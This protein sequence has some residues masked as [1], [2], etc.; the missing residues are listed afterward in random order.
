MPIEPRRDTV[1]DVILNAIDS[2]R[3]DVRD[4]REDGIQRGEMLRKEIS[5]LRHES[6]TELAALKPLVGAHSRQLKAYSDQLRAHSAQLDIQAKG[7]AQLENRPEKIVGRNIVWIA[8][9][10]G[11]AAALFGDLISMWLRSLAQ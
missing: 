6:R 3:V 4:L 9:G 2:V 1:T 11:M 7:L 5:D 8:A 10:A